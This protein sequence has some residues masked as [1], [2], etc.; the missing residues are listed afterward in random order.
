MSATGHQS[1][2]PK[3]EPRLREASSG[4]ASPEHLQ[5]TIQQLATTPVPQATGT[6]GH[7][8]VTPSAKGS[9]HHS[10]S[11]QKRTTPASVTGSRRGTQSA[12]GLAL[13]VRVD[14]EAMK[15]T[16]TSA[17]ER[18]MEKSRADSARFTQQLEKTAVETLVDLNEQ[19][20]ANKANL[21]EKI[22]A[23]SE[24]SEEIVL[25]TEADNEADIVDSPPKY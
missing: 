15:K 23:S 21:L 19:I 18:L 11:T 5:G 13:E 16:A 8:F 24:G 7:T 10:S 17:V 12:K 25:G 22:W 6:P 2:I 3:I 20:E 1:P 4:E 9:T 14:S